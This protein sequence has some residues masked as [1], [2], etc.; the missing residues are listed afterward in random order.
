MSARFEGELSQNVPRMYDKWRGALR[1]NDMSEE[2]RAVISAPRN[3]GYGNIQQMQDQL[4]KGGLDGLIDFA[5][6]LEKLNDKTRK[7]TLEGFGFSESGGAALAEI[8]ADPS[9]ARAIAA[10]A[11]Q[12]AEENQANDYL[13]NKFREWQTS[14]SNMLKQIEAG[15]RAI[16]S[17]IGDELKQ[18]LVSPFRD[19]WAE[20]S[21]EITHSD[22]KQQM[23]ESVI[24]F[25]HGLGFADVKSALDSIK[26][27]KDGY[28]IPGFAKGVGEGLRTIGESIKYIKES[29][30]GT[31]LSSEQIG[32]L[33]T[34]LL[35]L[36]IAAW[37]LGPVVG[38]VGT[39]ASSLI[40]LKAALDLGGALLELTGVTRG[41]KGL[42]AIDMVGGAAGLM[43]LAGGILT[44]I[45][46]AE[47]A[48]SKHIF[49]PPQLDGK[50]G[51]FRN[52]LNF[53][54]PNFG[55]LLLG[56]EKPED[57]KAAPAGPPRMSTLGA[58]DYWARKRPWLQKQS[59]TGGAEN[60]RS[61]FTP[62]SYTPSDAG[63]VAQE[64][65][66][67]SGRTLIQVRDELITTNELL[68]RSI[69]GDVGGDGPHG[70]DAGSG[71]APNMRYGRN[72][73]GGRNATPG[74]SGGGPKV[75]GGSG[76][77]RSWRNN[78][79]G[80]IEYGSYAKSM[81]A[82]G[83]DGRFAVFPNYAAGRKAQEHLLFES[84][85]Y[86]DLTLG[87]AIN[88]WAPGSEN[89]VPAYIAAM[90][91]DPNAKM[92]SFS[93][94]QRSALLD[95]MQRHEGWKVGTKQNSIIS[96]DGN[97]TFSGGSGNTSGAVDR[98]MSM[99]G[100]GAG[101][102][103]Q[104]LGA[105]M[106]SG[107]WCAD[108][109]NATLK[110]A[111]VKGS[112]SAMAASF[113]AWGKHVDLTNAQKGD[114]IEQQRGGRVGH[115]GFAT[116]NVQRDRN[117]AVTALEMVSGNYNGQVTKS[118]LSAAA[119]ADL[120]RSGEEITKGVVAATKPA[121][122]AKHVQSLTSPQG[123]DDSDFKK[124]GGLSADASVG[125][126]HTFNMSFHHQVADPHQMASIV[127]REL[128]NVLG[129]RS[130][131]IDHFVG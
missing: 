56:K 16:E 85:T 62:A 31:G 33:S 27:D 100:M 13:T 26:P 21:K 127:G 116:G 129:S 39:L 101:A 64:A 50:T 103:G 18:D 66:V 130:H 83:T 107:A 121:A 72:A 61:L 90:G 29:L 45:G 117:G 5:G 76:G 19:W 12:L 28:D 105:Y 119:I 11:K 102:S 41:L 91:G 15:W 63:Q 113:S 98:A 43:G 46:L 125:G 88:K 40:A 70:G 68:K 89:N 52:F 9:K 131:D 59:F 35:G 122:I 92:S 42:L 108:F 30:A 124:A 57:P 60:Y 54:D 44:L 34:E 49:D 22:M 115:V 20:V 71:G 75:S 77:S 93:P 106:H 86:K 84:K 55:N 114:V 94:A 37:I 120:R 82:I 96:P 110:S 67:D 87:Q 126:G 53:L 10:R 109:V 51:A 104:A 24:G 8:G 79:P 123:N 97:T 1:S 111:G 81:G 95:A 36:S 48:K 74:G 128:E 73:S 3:L 14:L 69:I 118:W 7:L 47:L 78:N 25:V 65:V 17:E 58:Q 32:K 99:L 38:I 23:H 4:M 112:G 6:R 2:D 80:N